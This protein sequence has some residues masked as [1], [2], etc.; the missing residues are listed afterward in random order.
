MQ[1]V[2]SMDRS[3]DSGIVAG[4]VQDELGRTITVSGGWTCTPG[5]LLGPG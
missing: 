5:P 1:L 2:V 4:K 3:P